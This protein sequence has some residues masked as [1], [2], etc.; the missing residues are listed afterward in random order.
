[1]K[2]TEEAISRPA[3]TKLTKMSVNSLTGTLTA[4]EGVAKDTLP[5]LLLQAE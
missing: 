3:T 4:E 5:R 2:A 1:M